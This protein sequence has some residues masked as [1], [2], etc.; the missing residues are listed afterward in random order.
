MIHQNV[1]N[2]ELVELFVTDES[3]DIQSDL[4]MKFIVVY[5]P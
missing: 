2:D 1:I 4:P 3:P 5:N